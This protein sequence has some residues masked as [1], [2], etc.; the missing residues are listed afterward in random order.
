MFKKTAVSPTTST[1]QLTVG[2]LNVDA[3][4]NTLRIDVFDSAVMSGKLS[5]ETRTLFMNAIDE[6]LA[7]ISSIFTAIKASPPE[8]TFD[9]FCGKLVVVS[10][11]HRLARNNDL[12]IIHLASEWD[13][14]HSHWSPKIYK[15]NLSRAIQNTTLNDLV[16]ECW[17]LLGDRIAMRSQGGNALLPLTQLCHNNAA[18]SI[19]K[20]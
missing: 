7:Y 3:V 19:V 9:I 1:P 2:E 17:T 14:L 5:V 16:S 8:A 12:T 15:D 10:P 11:L 4:I 20:Y 18:V 6:E 13:Y